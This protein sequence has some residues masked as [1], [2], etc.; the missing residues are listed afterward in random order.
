[1]G[2]EDHAA[3]E[4]EVRRE[5]RFELHVR[6]G[7]RLH[8]RAR[9]AA[10]EAVDRLLRCRLDLRVVGEPEV[11]VAAE[12]DD[13]LAG[14]A[15]VQA[16]RLEGSEIRVDLLLLGFADAGQ[17]SV[18]LVVNPA[19]RPSLVA[20]ANHD[21]SGRPRPVVASR[22]PAASWTGVAT[23]TSIR[24]RRTRMNTSARFLALTAALAATLSLTA[25]ASA[26]A[27]RGAFRLGAD[28]GMIGLQHFP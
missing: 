11:V 18:R 1:A 9:H 7:R 3:L 2:G 28:V 26:D 10:R 23:G 14:D 4:P 25:T 8:A 22:A 17:L 16:A 21:G 6:R 24:D 13:R 27:G 20:A 19:H 12:V 15:G 5:P